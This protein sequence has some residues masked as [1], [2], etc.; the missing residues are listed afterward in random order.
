MQYH[1]SRE[2]RRHE[3]SMI[4]R[5]SFVAPRTD[6][7]SYN[8]RQGK[9]SDRSPYIGFHYVTQFYYSLNWKH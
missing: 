3:E 7:I 4:L 2:K 1:R 9:G 6:F 5:R 8:L